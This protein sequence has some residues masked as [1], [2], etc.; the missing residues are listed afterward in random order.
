DFEIVADRL[1][2]S[3]VRVAGEDAQITVQGNLRHLLLRHSAHLT[4]W[5]LKGAHRAPF[6]TQASPVGFEWPAPDAG[7]PRP[8]A[9]RALDQPN[10]STRVRGHQSCRARHSRG[11]APPALPRAPG[12]RAG[13]H[14]GTTV[15]P[16]PR[17]V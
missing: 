17:R 12:R 11:P 7:G 15:A 14:S 10:Y 1:R 2:E 5:V 4:T 3:G 13:S 9:R 8:A 16:G 6:N